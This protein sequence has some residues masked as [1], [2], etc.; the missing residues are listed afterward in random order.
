MRRYTI[1][2][3]GCIFLLACF[4]P[5]D[6]ALASGSIGLQVA[7]VDG[8]GHPLIDSAVSAVVADGISVKMEPQGDGKYTASGL[9]LKLALDVTSTQFGE[10]SFDITL[11]ADLPNVAVTV[12]MTT[13]GNW[14]MIHGPLAGTTDLFASGGES[15]P[16]RQGGEDCSTAT[17]IP[18]LPYSDTG[19]TAGYLNDY[20]AAC[21]YSGSTAPDVVYSFSPQFDGL[22]NISL[23]G[24]SDYDTKLYVYLNDCGGAP[25]AC[26]DDAC[27]TPSFP[28]AYVSELVEVPL[29]AYSGTNENTYFIVIDGYGSS[30]GNYTLD[31]D[32]FQECDV[33]CTP[34][35][36][37]EGEPDCSSLN[38]GCNSVP[39]V[40]SPIACGETICGTSAYDGSTRDTD[41]Y[42]ITID[43][44]TIFTF[45][46]EAE[47]DVLFGKLGQYVD[48]VPGCD[49]ITGS[50]DPYALV[51]ECQPTSLVTA[52]LPAGTY[53]FFIG[54]QFTNLVTCGAEYTAT[55]TCEEIPDLGACC[56]PDGSC[57]D[58]SSGECLAQGGTFQGLG[59]ECFSTACPVLVEPGDECVD[60]LPIELPFSGVFD[61]TGA[62]DDIV[63]P[64]GVA[65]GPWKNMWFAVEGT[66]TTMTATTCNDGTAVS[67]TKISVFCMSCEDPV[68]VGGNDDNCSTAG[69]LS[70][71]E[72]CSQAGAI[73]FITVGNFTSSTT[74]GFIQ[75]DVF[76]DGLACEA[77]VLCIPEGA[78]CFADIFGTCDVM[79][80]AECM[81][82]GGTYQGD[83][84]DCGDVAGYTMELC[85]N[86]F[87]DISGSGLPG[88]SGDDSGIV[89][90]IGFSFTFFGDD[91]TDVG[92]GTNGYLTFGGDRT[93]YSNDAIPSTIDPNDLMAPYWDDYIVDGDGST[94]YLTMGTEPNRYFIA[95]WTGIR[96]YGNSDSNTFQVVLYEGT[97]CVE[98]RYGAI[99]LASPS[100]DVTVGIE[101]QDGTDGMSYDAA[102]LSAGDC[103]CF[104]P[105][106]P[107]NP[108]PALLPLDIKP[109]SCP[110]SFNAGSNGKL[111]VAL[112]GTAE[113]DIS[114]I[115]VNSIVMS[116]VDGMGGSVAPI[117]YS[118]P[119]PEYEDVATPFDGEMCDCHEMGA[120]GITD[121][122]LKWHS[123][124]VSAALMLSGLPHNT[125]VEVMVSGM[126]IDGQPFVAYDCIRK[127]GKNTIH[128]LHK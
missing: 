111:P 120:D 83:D 101:N 94:S 36:T 119:G 122:S 110:N 46:V 73:Y 77:T 2:F 59:T 118:D 8:G 126:L 18:A 42:E 9:P 26:N 25:V 33:V 61:N 14:V 58:V 62:T 79:T 54:P 63:V 81:A 99:T 41:W 91:H 80:E 7:V 88:P 57:L 84:T 4:L 76:D 75:L 43:T 50:V 93:D 78:C 47:F 116:R 90:P 112:L 117:L 95:Q 114:M 107:V 32:W 89:I 106:V 38:G 102:H 15:F 37:D 108:C 86:P 124:E 39:P 70:T 121:L 105:I 28:S 100:S 49:N 103:L 45:T 128:G 11:P 24:N 60:A 12:H 29:F 48:G 123:P 115:D 34:P 35:Y 21:P 19:T 125:Y 16:A 40:F 104:C 72:W 65:S 66:G 44:M 6:N 51:G 22:A 97:N 127:V 23:C 17:V 87:E 113:F 52:P 85:T 20:D 71:V 5:M 13:G 109:G 31:M 56:L 3:L 74:P 55:L 53:Y 92:M 64:C 27:A 1:C 67:D 96:Q 68:C 30:S 82:A 69:L 98:Y 10:S